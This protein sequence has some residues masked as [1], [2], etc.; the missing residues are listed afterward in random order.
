MSAL[1]ILKVRLGPL[2][3]LEVTGESCKEI[4]EALKGYEDL[5][6]Q[7]DAMC[8]DL[9]ERV[10]PEGDESAVKQEQEVQDEV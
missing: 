7:V 6:K 10:Y 1:I 3:S 2:V 8:A 4:C 5:N 9:A